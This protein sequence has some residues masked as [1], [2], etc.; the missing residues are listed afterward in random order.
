M[1]KAFC[2]DG[3]WSFIN[4][5][6]LFRRPARKHGSSGRDF[7][8][9]PRLSDLAKKRKVEKHASA[10]DYEPELSTISVGEVKEEEDWSD[11]LD[12]DVFED[13]KSAEKTPTESVYMNS[14]VNLSPVIAPEPKKRKTAPSYWPNLPKLLNSAVK[15]VTK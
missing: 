7:V 1:L 13:N 2:S 6:W 5:I 3:V 14:T 4:V 8:F 10:A 15:T 9:K 12:D 11:E